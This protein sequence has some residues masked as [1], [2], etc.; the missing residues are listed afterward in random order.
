MGFLVYLCFFV[1]CIT[2]YILFAIAK[3]IIRK[4]FIITVF[5]IYL[6][7][8]IIAVNEVSDACTYRTCKHG[9]YSKYNTFE[10]FMALLWTLTPGLFF[11]KQIR[12]IIKDINETE[13]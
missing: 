11:T 9:W 4:A 2:L 3:T 13:T 7:G 1:G 6:T 12:T 10:K 8:F 5:I